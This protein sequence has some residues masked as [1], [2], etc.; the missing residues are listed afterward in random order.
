MLS[1]IHCVAKGKVR[2]VGY[3]D[4]VE[5]YTKENELYGWVKNNQK[6]EFEVLVQ[7]SPDE[8]KECIKALNQGP[9]L[10]HVE[11]FSVDWKTPEKI[12]DE[13]KVMA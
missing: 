9:P 1:E 3:R 6:G 2:G 13:F 4:F 8:L 10:A 11:S 7:G 5:Q 12:F